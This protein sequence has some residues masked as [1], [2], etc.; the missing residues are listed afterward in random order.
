[1]VIDCLPSTHK[2]LGLSSSTG[3]EKEMEKE[4]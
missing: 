1:M 4:I 3:K 2:A